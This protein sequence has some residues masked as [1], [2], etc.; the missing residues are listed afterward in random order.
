MNEEVEIEKKTRMHLEKI[1]VDKKKELIELKK[2]MI[3]KLQGNSNILF[4]AYFIF[5]VT[6]IAALFYSNHISR[7]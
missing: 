6:L 5:S 2:V 4:K 1:L 7:S 3:K